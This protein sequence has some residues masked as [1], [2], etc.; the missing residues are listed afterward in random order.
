MSAPVFDRAA[1]VFFE[2][3]VVSSAVANAGV[4]ERTTAAKAQSED[5]MIVFMAVFMSVFIL[6]LSV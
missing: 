1:P 2:K 3:S 6:I 5:F 4:D